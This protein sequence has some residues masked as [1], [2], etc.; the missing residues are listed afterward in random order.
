MYNGRL[1]SSRH[2]VAENKAFGSLGAFFVEDL[3]WDI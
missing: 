1:S 3:G 2:F